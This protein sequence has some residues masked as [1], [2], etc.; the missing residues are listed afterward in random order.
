[1]T[2]SAGS[3]D[4][5][6][7]SRRLDHLDLGPTYASTENVLRLV[8]DLTRSNVQPDEAVPPPA[9][10]DH[11][12]KSSVAVCRSIRCSA[13][14]T[15]GRPRS[16]DAGVRRRARPFSRQAELV[17]AIELGANWTFVYVETLSGGL[18]R[19]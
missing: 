1:M 9:A 17:E 18:V 16:S 12:R 6:A 15:S 3:V 10:V 4:S 19:H 2:V 7:G 13:P 5:Q 14:T 8:V 11:A